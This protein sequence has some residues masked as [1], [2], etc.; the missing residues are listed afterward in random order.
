LVRHKEAGKVLADAFEIYAGECE[1]AVM[2]REFFGK[3]VMV[4]LGGRFASGSITATEEEREKAKMGLRGIL[5][6]IPDLERRK[7]ILVSTKDNLITMSV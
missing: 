7:K 1:K 2:V 3:E 6:D 4:L 5:L